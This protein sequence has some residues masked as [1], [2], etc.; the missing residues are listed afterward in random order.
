VNRHIWVE[1]DVL[2]YRL[3]LGM[4]GEPLSDHLAGTL[5]RTDL[6]AG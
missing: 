2:N 6:A 5:R 3:L 1:D 4:N